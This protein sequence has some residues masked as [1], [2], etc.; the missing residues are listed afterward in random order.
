MLRTL[1]LL[2][3]SVFLLPTTLSYAQNAH[4][5][6]NA[7]QPDRYV[8]FRL[9]PE[10]G[11]VK[12][13]E[14]IWIGIEQSIYPHW[15][16]YWKNPGDSGSSP[17]VMWNLPQGFKVGDVL[18]PA[19]K[20]I[21]FGPL[22]NYGYEDHAILLQ[23]LTVPEELPE[24]PLT[25]T[26]DIEVLVCKVECIPEFGTY[27]LTLNGPD[28]AS[29]NNEAYLKAAL[30]QVPGA[31]DWDASY[32][33]NNGELVLKIDL[34]EQNIFSSLDESSIALIPEDWGIVK[35]TAAPGAEVLEH[36]LILT[37]ERGERPLKDIKSLNGLISYEVDGIQ[38][39]RAFTAKP[40][41]TTAL[42]STNN[43]QSAA[44]QTAS[45]IG[46]LEAV[47]YAFLGGLIL[48]LMPC[49][50]PV[51]SIKALSL[52]KIAEKEKSLA[53]RHGYAYTL[54]VVLS[55]LAIAGLLIVLQAAGAQIGWGFQ[56]QNALVVSLLA[57]LL[58]IIGLNLS[59]FFEFHLGAS[60]LGQKLTQGNGLKSSF[61]TGILA[62]L[63]ATPCTAPF[64]AGA[65]GFALTQSAL[66]SLIIF[67]SLGF[68]LAAPY[69]VLAV[70]PATQRYLPKPGAWM[71]VFK[72]FLAFPMFASAAWLFWVAIRQ[73]GATHAL[74][75]A[76]GA[77]LIAFAI[78]LFKRKPASAPAKFIL[79]LLAL[80]LL[81]L[82]ILMPVGSVSMSESHAENMENSLAFGEPYSKEKLAK[83]LEGDEPVFVEMTADWCITC[84]ANHAVAI[85]IT[86]TKELFREKKIR[87]LIGDWT[88][89]DPEI[90]KF[91]KS[92]GRSG[93]PIY[94]Y[95]APPK[96]TGKSRP[97]PVI[98]PQILTPGIVANAI[99]E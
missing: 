70:S 62:T 90:T 63:V 77:T 91:L 27:E 33:E 86:A 11:Q 41:A 17:R 22:L 99:N 4:P 5:D 34:P 44:P 55:F 24:G 13:G 23:K 93:V 57:Y 48:N 61:F 31:S 56:L 30:A 65:I 74:S 19:P 84:K 54:G 12:P 69:L 49:V 64:M 1:I 45:G 98:L 88:N 71:D 80:V 29:E 46:F 51:L 75:L 18:W 2:I 68:G 35:N 94:V 14:E 16:T 72:Q 96:G 21:S 15:H 85:N 25:L 9:L 3:F 95:Y 66:V 7:A 10:R 50:F 97:D 82:S 20:K 92:Y 67:G 78:W 47:L 59:G 73:T 42:S 58:F 6:G 52:V 40:I 43:G 8:K 36:K 39:A 83:L 76:L 32:Y 53:R 60:N 87:Y 37:Q 79:R 38:L 89:Q 28:A 81:G 26:A